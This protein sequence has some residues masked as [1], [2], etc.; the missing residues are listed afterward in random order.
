[1]KVKF[2]LLLTAMLAESGV[3][4]P[5]VVAVTVTVPLATIV[6]DHVRLAGLVVRVTVLLLPSVNFQSETVT[7]DD[8]VTVQVAV[9]P[10]VS[11]DVQVSFVTVPPPVSTGFVRGRPVASKTGPAEG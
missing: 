11:D 4:A 8:G 3:A 6:P 9:P 1:M 7:P 10:R 5:E 2:V